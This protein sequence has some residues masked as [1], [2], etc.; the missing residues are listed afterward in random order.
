MRRYSPKDNVQK[1]PYYT[2]RY[3]VA[4]QVP[5]LDVES[6]E[7]FASD[8]AAIESKFTVSESYIQLD[9]LV[10]YIDI[11]DNLG[12][13]E[14]LR[15]ERAYTQLS[16]LSAIDWL[17]KD[18]KFEIFY[19]LLSMSR[20]K[21][22][23]IKAYIDEAQPVKSVQSLWRSADWS[24]REMYDMFGI[25]LINHP[26]PKRILMPDDWEGFPLRKSYPL[27]G[28]EA[29]S[30]YEVDK[31]FGKEHRETIGAELR[32]CAKVDRY[33][34]ERFSRLGFEVPKGADISGGE[35]RKKVQYQE[36]GGVFLI[37]RFDEEKTVII[38]DKDR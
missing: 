15:D 25:K 19:Q 4:P 29:A 7:E 16:E 34:T 24:E 8:L 36:D 27:Q 33:D 20:R 2:D 17:A 5:K 35:K 32:D 30:W 21:R 13:L 12:V 9:Q 1:K 10:V 26:F 23:R 3:Y 38:R 6:D 31:I 18:G 28:D 11:A 22:I 14:L 37:D